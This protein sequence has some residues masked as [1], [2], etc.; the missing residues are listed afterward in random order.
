MKEAARLLK[1]MDL[2]M[3]D[4]GIKEVFTFTSQDNPSVSKVK[5]EIKKAFDSS[6]LELLHIEGG[7][8]E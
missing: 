5:E 8:I 2:D 7:K 1:T 6:D 4:V 3:G